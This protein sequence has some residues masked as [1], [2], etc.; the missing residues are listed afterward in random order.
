MKQITLRRNKPYMEPLRFGDCLL[1]PWNP[2]H[3]DK[4]IYQTRQNVPC[5]CFSKNPRLE[6][7]VKSRHKGEKSQRKVLRQD[8]VRLV[9]Q[10]DS[11]VHTAS[12]SLQQLRQFDF[13]AE[14]SSITAFLKC[15]EMIKNI[16]RW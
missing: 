7:L 13:C 12:P 4:Y 14:H 3:P 2:F 16:D 6:K 11:G 5:T 10:G 8:S 9:L 1:S 15:L